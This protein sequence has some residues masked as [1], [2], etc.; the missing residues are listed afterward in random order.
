MH[1]MSSATGAFAPPKDVIFE[2]LDG[3]AVVL[4]L[5]SGVYFTLNDSGTRLWEL[6]LEHRDLDRVRDQFLREFDVTP[7]TLET[8]LS[9]L[10][11]ELLERGL[12][13]KH[14]D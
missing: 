14:R 10:V 9:T 4:D 11:R 8:D 6:I 5:R 13:A 1:F 7:A 12:L 3:E 2:I